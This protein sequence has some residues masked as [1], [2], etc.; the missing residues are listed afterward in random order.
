MV[1]SI[2]LSPPVAAD[3][4]SVAARGLAPVST[5]WPVVEGKVRAEAVAVLPLGAA[6]AFPPPVAGGAVDPGK[7][8]DGIALFESVAAAV[9]ELPGS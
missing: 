8:K 6:K 3:L 2:V 9:V 5:D 1:T 4:L 7:L